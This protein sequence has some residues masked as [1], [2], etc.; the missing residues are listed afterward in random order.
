MM[1]RNPGLRGLFAATLIFVLASCSDFNNSPKP[2]GGDGPSPQRPVGKNPFPPGFEKPNDGAFSEQKM[3]VN[4]G[5]N[6]VA[7][8][9]RNFRLK[10]E[11][12]RDAVVTACEAR[13]DASSVATAKSAFKD[14]MLAFHGVGAV[15]FGPLAEDKGALY[16]RI[17]SWPF[18]NT[19]GIDQ[20]VEAL[21]RGASK[22]VAELGVNLRGLGAIEYLLFEP[23][24]KSSC[25][26]RAFPQIKAWAAKP[27]AEK[28]LDRCRTAA[29][30]AGDVMDAALYLEKRWD[31]DEGNYSKSLIDG[32]VY[33]DMKEALTAVVHG[34]FAF[35]K[36]KDERLGRPLG[37][38]KLCTNDS[39]KCPENA[40]HPLSGL[41][42][43]A[44]R[45]QFDNFKEVFWGARDRG[46][47][48]F[49]IDDLL[50]DRG[51]PGAVDELRQA[52]DQ[53]D[54]SLAAVEAEGTTL[55][56]QIEAMLPEDCRAT[57]VTDRRVPVCA[58]YQDL[59][60]ITVL[61]KTDVLTM[62][63]LRAPPGYQG[64]N[65]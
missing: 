52:M 60:R 55:Q 42:L 30:L 35:E 41:A 28:A 23:E 44:I 5:V 63:S 27:A 25:N 64:D 12:L 6:V 21:S 4:L 9:V 13:M 19:C 40:E 58:M 53:L 15:S 2:T 17:Y 50:V 39:W 8:D 7:K 45:T 26:P 62:L 16:S 34:M 33:P 32:S 48:A 61:F 37:L 47:R 22:D 1:T 31:V 11:I 54:V 57:T 14:A 29:K 36:L 46:A 3:L 20:E 59:R 24:L 49:G 38:H 43:E 18:I 10:S 56:E 65:D 51:Y